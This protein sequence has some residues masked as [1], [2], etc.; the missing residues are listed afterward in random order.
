MTDSTLP[1]AGVEHGKRIL[2]SVIE[3]R[4]RNVSSKP[5]VSLPVN[6]QDLSQGYKD[7]SFWQLNNYANHAANWLRENLPQTLETF[8]CFAYAGPKDLRYSILAVAAAKLQKVMVMP[9]PLITP[10][11]QNRILSVKNCKIYLRPASMADKVAE[12]LK[13]THGFQVITVPEI[14]EIMKEEEAPVFTYPKSWE[15]GKDDP[16]LV[17]HTSGT[18]GNPKPLT[19]SHGMMA[20]PDIMT[21]LPDLE[22]SVL[23]KFAQDRWYTPLPSLHLV[24]TVMVLAM[25]S[26]LESTIVIGPAVQ[27]SANLVVDIL[28]YGRVDGALMI[29]SLIE[30]LCLTDTGLQSLRSLKCLLYTGAPL[31]TKA[32]EKLVSHVHIAP[33]AGSTEGGLFLT[34]LHDKKD[35]WDYISFQAH[36]SA[37]LVPRFD[38]LHELVFVRRPGCLVPLVFQVKPDLERFETNDMLVE[39]PVHK[40]LWKFI[41]RG[42]DYVNFSHGDGMHA[43]LIEAE[44]ENH[45]AVKAA[46]IGENGRPAPVLLV[47]LVPNAVAD[48]EKSRFTA[49]LQ[50]FIDNANVRCHDC[51]KLSLDRLILAQHEK[52]FVRNVKG[53]VVRM[54]TLALYKD[55]ISAIFV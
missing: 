14:E 38:K 51:V 23:H 7:V 8:Q 44:I 2:V 49:S 32:G 55:E 19:W 9:S 10:E 37:E 25:T 31:N 46:L 27:P 16:W 6:E 34:K 26:F 35:A 5:W 18:T 22:L 42:D 39:H 1:L 40:G 33:M 41:G 36:A 11:A 54:Q 47:E 17:F 15:E 48:N 53:G 21:S 29:P 3:S 43:S 45:P 4:A 24:G 52:P 50:P 12:I 28:Q 20:V 13:E 30:E